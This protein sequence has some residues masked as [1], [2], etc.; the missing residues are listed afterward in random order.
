MSTLA[1]VHITLSSTL[2]LLFA[3][4][5]PLYMQAVLDVGAEDAVTIFAPVA[6]GALFGLRAVPWIVA[7]LGKTRTVALG[8]FG[9]AFCL[10]VLGFVETIASLL[11]RV[12]RLNPFG[13]GIDR[14]FGLSILVALTMLFA[15]PMGFCYALLN[16]PAQTTLHERT[17]AAMRGRVIA[18]Q[19]VLANGVALI[20]LV[21]IGGIA[22]L[23]GV[24]SVVLAI[25]GLVAVAGGVSIYLDQRWLGREGSG[26]PPSGGEHPR[27]PS[28][29]ASGTP[30]D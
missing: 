26:P 25:G 21:V 15:G 18:A 16:T 4:L 1:M 12:D 23:Y 27:V 7:R 28:T 10:G 17:P 6:I 3:I 20:P 14:V 30:L 29:A 2:I 5:V 19:M 24:S 9:I 11:E 13:Q 8:M 22:D